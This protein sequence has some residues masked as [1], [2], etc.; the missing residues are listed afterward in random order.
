MNERLRTRARLHTPHD[1]INF[2]YLYSVFLFDYNV[3]A[4]INLTTVAANFNGI[5]VLFISIDVLNYGKISDSSFISINLYIKSIQIVLHLHFAQ[6]QRR[7][8]VACD[9]NE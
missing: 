8:A 5:I 6:E 7:H 1:Q 4:N 9:A 2:A 3:M